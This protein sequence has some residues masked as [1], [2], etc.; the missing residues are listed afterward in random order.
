MSNKPNRGITLL[1]AALGGEGGGVLA[2]WI[3]EACVTLGLPVQSTSIP[4]V[5]QR[6]G[7]TTYYLE[8]FP[9]PR[10]QLNKAEPVMSL[11]PSPGEVDI[12]LASELLEAARV[13]QN[14]FVDA[15]NTTLIFSTHREYAVLEKTAMSDGRVDSERIVETAKTLA[16]K[17]IFSDLKSI[18]TANNTV[19][20]TV[21]FGA[22]V[23]AKV[24]PLT[25]EACQDAI[26]KSGKAVEASLKGFAAGI[27]L[28]VNGKADTI[29][30]ISPNKP[31]LVHASRVKKFPL[32]VQ[33]VVSN[34]YELTSDYQDKA[35]AE[36]YL[37]RLQQV[38]EVEYLA[39][40]SEFKV[41]REVARYLALWMSYEDVIRVADLKSR[42][43]RLQ[44]VRKEV[45][46]KPSEP[47]LL[48]E[49]LKPGISEICAVLPKSIADKITAYCTKRNISLNFKLH[50][51]TNT[52]F[53]FLQL[54]FL[55]NL[56][57]I[58]KFSS[59]FKDEQEQINNW[60]DLIKATNK[61][62]QSI[63][64]ELALCGNLVKGYGSTSERGHGN[65]SKILSDV[66]DSISITK[67]SIE[68]LAQR[69]SSARKAALADPE[70]RAVS[71][72]L[73]LPEVPPKVQII[74]FV[75]RG[76]V[77][78]QF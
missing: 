46:A 29:S 69:I 44:R 5:S 53:G 35:Y 68:E 19:I 37:D 2:D 4:G 73:G 9:I 15:S 75:K 41:T 26:R 74:K 32:E 27:E 50:L 13:I 59:Q 58:R 30:A 3:I 51:K 71:K 43:S 12:V 60:L 18:A 39:H 49:F 66:K 45:G 8:I 57:V 40:P 17:A 1:I 63:A 14:G 42:W 38:F 48:T 54:V 23:G 33:E 47:M 61:L 78:K 28:V 10:S 52:L 16:H 67:L 77:V 11:V 64:Y 31:V 70:G 56:K 24:L 76:S 21:M 62:D 25:V 22:L 55:R 34:G 7:A 72:I 20:N 65:L 36:L 6:T